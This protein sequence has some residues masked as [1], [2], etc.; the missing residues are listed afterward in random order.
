MVARAEVLP[1][2]VSVLLE[3]YRGYALMGDAQLRSAPVAIA[4]QGEEI[5]SA[6]SRAEARATIDGWLS[7]R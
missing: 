7:P 4:F 3:T 1:F 2:T 5:D 6:K